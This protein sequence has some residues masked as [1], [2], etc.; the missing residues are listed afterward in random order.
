[1]CRVNCQHCHQ[2]PASRPRG[3][4]W[5]CYYTAGVRELYAGSPSKSAHRGVGTSGKVLP[6]PTE[7]LPG[8]EEKIRELQRRAAAGEFLFHPADK[9]LSDE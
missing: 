8:T 9:Q 1:M 7:A 3:L 5:T 4:C 6:A 2:S